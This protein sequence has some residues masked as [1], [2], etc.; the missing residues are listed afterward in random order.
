L[1]GWSSSN[2]TWKIFSCAPDGRWVPSRQIAETAVIDAA[3]RVSTTT[4]DG[5]GPMAFGMI[6]N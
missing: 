6:R 4:E 2:V 3:F 1:S 5:G